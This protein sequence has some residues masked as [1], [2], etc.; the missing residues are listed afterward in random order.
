[1][2][3]L[4][5]LC[6]FVLFFIIPACGQTTPAPPAHTPPANTPAPS[7]APMYVAPF[8]A[9][10]GYN[11]RIFS[12]PG[13]QRVSLNGA[14]GSFDYNILSRIS[15]AG[16]ISG[17][18]RDQ[19]LNGNLS[20]YSAMAGPQIYPFKHRRKLTPFVHFLFGES[21][22]RNDYPAY[23]GFP[24]TVKAD[25]SFSWE[26]GGGFDWAFKTHWEIR[27]IQIDYAPTKFLGSGTQTNYRAS[28]GVVYR[29]GEKK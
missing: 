13:Y 1:M 20:I 12:Q 2:K 5:A 21:F 23:G 9:S 25:S 6:G 17:G 22:Y 24:K 7:P 26:G 10:A 16:E 15:V 3:Q 4:G 29:F 8:E 28:V 18:A 14:Y 27:L 11:L 19:G